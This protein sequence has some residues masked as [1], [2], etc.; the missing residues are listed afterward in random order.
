M[1]VLLLA[2]MIALLPLRGWVGNAM[3]VDMAAQ[4]VAMAPQAALVA[5]AGAEASAMPDDCPMFGKASE[6]ETPVAD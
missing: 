3:A 1:R 5:E 6:K 2:L 4:Q